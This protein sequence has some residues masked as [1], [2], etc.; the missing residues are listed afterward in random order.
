MKAILEMELPENCFK[1]MLR[2]YI[3][4]H[5]CVALNKRDVDYLSEKRHP[6]CPLKI[7]EDKE[8]I[9]EKCCFDC[10]YALSC[11]KFCEN[12][13]NRL[14]QGGNWRCAPE[15]RCINFCNLYKK[16]SVQV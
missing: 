16:A 15:N 7:I 12:F 2:H 4:Y 6:D 9:R 14:I 8:M 11:G 10:G 13:R 3:G 5:C 1:C